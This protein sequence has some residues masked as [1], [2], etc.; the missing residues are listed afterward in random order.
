[1]RST[2]TAVASVS[3]GGRGGGPAGRPPVAA[4]AARSLADRW[5]RTVLTR[6]RRW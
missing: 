4:R 6:A 3:A 2:S 1:V 5:E